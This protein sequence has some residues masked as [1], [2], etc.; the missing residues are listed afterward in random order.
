MCTQLERAASKEVADMVT[1][2]CRYTTSR[3]T[4]HISDLGKIKADMPTSN[5]SPDDPGP[6]VG[7]F[8]RLHPSEMDD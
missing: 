8:R 2:I 6:I 3:R 5:P 7:A 4:V 1:Y